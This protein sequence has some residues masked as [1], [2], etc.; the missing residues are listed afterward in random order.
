M[1]NISVT[2]WE[3]AR[4]LA[5]ALVLASM[6][7]ATLFE[8]FKI[9]SSSMVPTLLV[10]DFLFVN[11]FKYGLREPCS[12]NRYGSKHSPQR[13]DVVV[14]E[15]KKGY[16]CGLLLGVGSLNFIKR[17]VAIPGDKVS[18][19][20]K[21]LYVNDKPAHKESL[22]RYSYIDGRGNHLSA[23]MY[24]ETLG[25]VKYNTLIMHDRMGMDLAPIVVPDGHY[26]VMGDNRDNSLDS[27]AWNYPSWG[28]V[29]AESI[30]G[31]ASWI[32]WSWDKKFR[33]RFERPFSSLRA[34][35]VIVEPQNQQGK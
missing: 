10:G 19:N 35:E 20:N 4:V 18:Y 22:E 1:K 17:V 30:L 16:L 31:N 13:G 3:Y 33:P 15:K 9:P 5:A 12:G 2:V 24:E 23:K 26:V 25:E 32:F 21:T 29:K 6:I 28:F 14:F 34:E 7:R 11:K 8:P 27:R